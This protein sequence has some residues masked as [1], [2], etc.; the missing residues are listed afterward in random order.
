MNNAN[1]SPNNR[2]I[3]KSLAN[4]VAWGAGIGLITSGPAGVP[5]GAGLA[6]VQNVVQAAKPHFPLDSPIPTN[7]PMGPG[8]LNQSNKPSVSNQTLPP[9]EQ[10]QRNLRP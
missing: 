9:S 1:V 2:E 4:D 7:L 5:L 6:A 8:Q 3:T 10:W